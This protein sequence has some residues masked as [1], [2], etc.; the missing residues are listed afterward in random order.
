MEI[1]A[2]FDPRTS[3]LS[4]VVY[5]SKTRD[6]VV[7]DPVLDYEPQSSKTWTESA[8]ALV[9]FIKD[10]QLTLHYIL[11]TH[12]HADHLS[13]SQIVQHAFPDAKIGVGERITE[14]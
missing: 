8:D 4:Y 13:G 6:A 2:F 10:N 12:A 1:Q 9:R 5:D 3:T 14:V 11:E 7:I